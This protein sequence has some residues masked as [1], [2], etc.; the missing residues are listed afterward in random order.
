MLVPSSLL[1]RLSL[2][3]TN[4]KSHPV[5]NAILTLPSGNSKK[6]ANAPP[7]LAAEFVVTDLSARHL[8]FCL[9]NFHQKEYELFGSNTV[10]YL[11]Q[12]D[13]ARGILRAVLLEYNGETP[14]EYLQRLME[15]VISGNEPDPQ[16]VVVSWC[17]GHCIRAVRGHVR[18]GNFRCQPNIDKKNIIN[19]AMR[20][21]CHVQSRTNFAEADKGTKCWNWLLNRLYLNLANSNIDLNAA[22]S[23]L[24]KRPNMDVDSLPANELQIEASGVDF[25]LVDEG[26]ASNDG[27]SREWHY[28]ANGEIILQIIET[29]IDITD[30]NRN[31]LINNDLIITINNRHYINGHV[32]VIPGLRMRVPILI[33]PDINGRFLNPLYSPELARYFS[34]QWWSCIVI[35]S[36]LIKRIAERE[37]RTTATIEVHHKI[38]KTMDI[39]K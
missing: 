25:W 16:K 29:S 36:N 12:S 15:N 11:V 1:Y 17:Y 8:A 27:V 34:R 4:N 39:A 37:R 28:T 6:E 30:S 35:W 38:L 22:E 5:L 20:M 24:T 18:S 23:L 26:Q 19:A 21:W 14:N 13:C 2:C 7:V 33:S 3:T 32:L 9:Q 31:N 10:P